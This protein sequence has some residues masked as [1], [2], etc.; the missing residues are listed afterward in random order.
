MSSRAWMRLP[1]TDMPAAMMHLHLCRSWGRRYRCRGD[2]SAPC[3]PSIASRPLVRTNLVA[4]RMSV[5]LGA[6]SF[7]PSFL[8]GGLEGCDMSE[9]CIARGKIEPGGMCVSSSAPQA[10]GNSFDHVSGFLLQG[11]T[12]RAISR[13]RSAGLVHAGLI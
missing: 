13:A 1:T 10:K 6:P 2:L 8:P 5:A 4:S 3:A 9:S 11:S 12:W 7:L